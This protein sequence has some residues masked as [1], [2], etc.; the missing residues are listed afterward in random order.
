MSL[1]A[2]A[3]KHM[4]AAGMPQEAI[5]A[6]VEEMEATINPGPTKRQARNARYY[7]EHKEKLR[8][9]ASEKRLERLSASETSEPNGSPLAPKETSPEPPKEITPS[10]SLQTEKPKQASA[11]RA[12]RFPA[13]FVLDEKISSEA[14]R[15]GLKPHEI[16]PE[17]EKF[18]DHHVSKGNVMADWLAAWRT[19]C[20]NAVQ[21]AARQARGP[22]GL[23][24]NG[25]SQETTAD[26]RAKFAAK[27]GLDSNGNPIGH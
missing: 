14:K 24:S 22:P 9:K 13:D 23:F 10:P 2:A 1:I 17:F 16:E 21:F 26:I 27:H 20:R 4:L 5:V 15:L 18:R 11:K 3:I 25:S 19:W 6:A 7:E 8:L 12:C